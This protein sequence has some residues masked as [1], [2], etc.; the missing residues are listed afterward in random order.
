MARR[1]SKATGGFFPTPDR[2]LK[3]VAS[4][5]KPNTTDGVIRV[6][7]PCAGD[8]RA[9]RALSN[10]RKRDTHL[11]GC[12]MER[13]RHRA[14]QLGIHSS[15]LL[16]GDFFQVKCAP[17]FFQIVYLNP[18]Y[19]QDRETKR[20]EERFLRAVVPMVAEGGVDTEGLRQN[21]EC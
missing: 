16:R 13:G 17:G 21:T 19:D 3:T 8:G 6:L 4:A 15:H 14:A 20:L 11:Y 10:I 2:I 12:E 1:E 5:L 18:P 9:L 7:D